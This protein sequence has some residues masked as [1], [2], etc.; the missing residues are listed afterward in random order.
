[1]SKK[2]YSAAEK[3][4][5]LLK[6]AP[7]IKKGLPLQLIAIWVQVPYGTFKQWVDRLEKEGLHT[8][9]DHSPNCKISIAELNL[10]L[11]FFELNKLKPRPANFKR[12]CRLLKTTRKPSTLYVYYRSQARSLNR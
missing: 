3:T 1:M 11:S 5:I 2:K 8:L 7:R 9:E 12:A 6:A 10:I 4:Q